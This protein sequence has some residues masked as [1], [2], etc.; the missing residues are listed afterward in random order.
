MN[1]PDRITA[2]L[3]QQANEELEAEINEKL[4]LAS[5]FICNYI[6]YRKVAL[7]VKPEENYYALFNQIKKELFNILVVKKREEKVKA[8]IAKVDS[9]DSQI[10]ELRSSIQ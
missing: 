9:L 4:K 6:G 7:D 2:L 10:E 5:E 3:Y 8:F 1:T